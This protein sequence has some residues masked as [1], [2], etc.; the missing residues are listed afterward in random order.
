[1]LGLRVIVSE[2]EA[3]LSADGCSNNDSSAE[4]ETEYESEEGAGVTQRVGSGIIGA[5]RV[6]KKDEAA[7]WRVYNI[8]S[9]ALASQPDSFDT[10]HISADSDSD[11]DSDAAPAPA[12]A[13]ASAP[14]SAMDGGV[15]EWQ[16]VRSRFKDYVTQPKPSGYQSLHMTLQHRPTGVAMEIQIRSQRMHQEAEYGAAAHSKYKALVLPAAATAPG[17]DTVDE[18]ANNKSNE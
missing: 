12:S 1:M 6:Q 3:V 18:R 17:N 11:S 7:V 13:S 8:I 15:G 5:Q 9:S 16:E 10:S 2:K 4:G 14:T